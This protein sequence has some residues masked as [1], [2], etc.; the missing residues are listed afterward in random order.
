M[1][2]IK[3]V[4]SILYMNILYIATCY[5]ITDN[6]IF[7]A[8]NHSHG[9]F[10]LG[11]SEIKLEVSVLSLAGSHRSFLF[12]SFAGAHKTAIFISNNIFS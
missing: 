3:I 11:I 2:G 7:I 9:Y 12:F 1:I 4:S 10:V 5:T 8:S 6:Y